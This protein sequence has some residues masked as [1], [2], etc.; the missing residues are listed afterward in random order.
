MPASPLAPHWT[1][2][3]GLDYLNH[4]S[5]GACPRAVLDAQQELRAAM[6]RQPVA[7]LARELGDRVDAAREALAQFVGADAEGLVVVP[8]ATTGVNAVLGSVAPALRPGDE[9]LTTDHAYN[10]CRNALEVVA[11]ERGARVVVATVPFPLDSEDEVVAAV[12]DAV[13]PRTRLALLD[14]VTSPTAL[15]LPV[16]RLV[17]ALAER[18]VDSLVDG[19]HAPGMVP[20]DLRALGAAFYT[21][22]C[23]KWLCAPKGAGFLW[24]RKDRREGLRPPVVSHGFNRRRPGRS[25]LHDEFDWMG[26]VD[27]TPFLCV[28]EALRVVGGMVPGGW[29][30]VMERNRA[31]ALAARRELATALGCALP[32][33][34]A[35]LGSMAS[36]PLPAGEAR[37]SSPLGFDPLQ[38]EL[39][40]SHGIEVPVFAWPE[41]PRRL[42]RLSAQLYNDA[43]Q[44][45]RLGAALQAQSPAGAA[46]EAL[47]AR[48]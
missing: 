42:V 27:P 25:R 1:L 33:P 4:G 2:E 8:N 14:H 31:L 19:A 11:A 7:F 22:N 46:S 6:E 5:F 17:A 32:C 21:G 16:G 12:L 23:H 45:R 9:L 34:D 3:P 15:V 20:L 13:T 28:P 39:L 36:L 26:T 48:Q 41:P 43:E 30:E 24:V 18:G 37:S 35:M 29:P 40:A 44:Y 10:A 47:R 38:E